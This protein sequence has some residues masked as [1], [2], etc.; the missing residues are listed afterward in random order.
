[1]NTNAAS[2][3]IAHL[4]ADSLLWYTPL[5]NYYCFDGMA[6][7]TAKTKKIENR[8]TSGRRQSFIS[9]LITLLRNYL[10]SHTTVYM[11]LSTL[12]VDSSLTT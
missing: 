6:K 12:I 2:N 7:H 9:L 4:P 11:T 8:S 5:I 1:M 3:L 10:T